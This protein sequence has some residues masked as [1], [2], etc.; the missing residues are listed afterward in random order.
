MITIL[1]TTKKEFIEDCINSIDRLSELVTVGDFNLEITNTT[2]RVEND[3][4]TPVI[5][6]NDTEFPYLFPTLEL[7]KN[8][9]L[10][11][12]FYKLG[13]MQKA[14]EFLLESDELH[15]HLLI[16]ANLQFGYPITKDQIQFLKNTSNHNLAIAYNFGTV[17][18]NIDINTLQT[19]YEEAI[20][21]GK[22]NEDKLFSVKQYVNLLLDNNLAADGE[23]LLRSVLSK[24]E[25]AEQKNALHLLLINCL[26]KQ[27]TI[28]YNQEALQ[29][30]I[31]LQEK[32]ISFLEKNDLKVNAGLVLIGASEIANYQNEFIKSKNLIS[33]AILY[34]TEA[35]I[36]EFL[37]EATLQKA[38]LLYN[39][40]KNGS[41][42][43][44]KPAINTFQN[45]LKVF[46]RDTHPQKFADIH[47]N[48]ALIYSEIKVSDQEK[49]IWTAFC[50]SSFKEALGFYN[51]DEFPYQY[52]MV[53]H[54]YATALMG[55]PEAKLHSNLD[56]A[57]AM[58][59]E[60]LTIRSVSDYPFERALSLLNQLELYWL[61]HNET[62]EDELKSYDEMFGKVNEIKTLVTDKILLAKADE[63]LEKLHKLKSVIS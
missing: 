53:S 33:K 42:Q 5:D 56:K 12:V 23:K 45:A 21:T 39:W 55:F 50:A 52:A 34:F 4:L 57:F 31:G 43:Y 6:W 58:F 28:P 13:N 38:T 20:K 8:N 9:L 18:E 25:T 46:K 16:V 41:P 7:T 59:E 30:L 54:N 14:F 37:G 22:L 29:E 24:A 36:P 35:D 15:Q 26:T 2:I 51:K 48:L 3:T 49:P 47:H 27:L 40:S 32:S 19:I 61:I 44:Y 1:T 11:I 60:A 17:D 62:N 10:G 63:Q